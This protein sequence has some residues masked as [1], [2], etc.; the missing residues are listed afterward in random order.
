M[1]QVPAFA[2]LPECHC[3]EGVGHLSQAPLDWPDG[4]TDMVPT[5]CAWGGSEAEEYE[6]VAQ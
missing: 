3:R 5:I 1:T 6:T 4:S 2:P